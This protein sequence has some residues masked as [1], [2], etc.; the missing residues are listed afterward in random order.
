MVTGVGVVS[1]LGHN[2]KQT[3]KGVLDGQS[4][5]ATYLNDPV[6]RNPLKPY[7][8]GLVKNFDFAAWKVPV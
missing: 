6:L 4:G 2:S 7:T 5:L 1:S 3:W 8:L